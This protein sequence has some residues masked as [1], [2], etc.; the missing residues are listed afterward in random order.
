MAPSRRYG[1][2]LPLP[3]A[4][5]PNTDLNSTSH[6][7]TVPQRGAHHQLVVE[8]KLRQRGPLLASHDF[9]GVGGEVKTQRVPADAVQARPHRGCRTLRRGHVAGGRGYYLINEGVLLNQVRE[10]G[11]DPEVVRESQRRRYADVSVVDKVIELDT[12]WRTVRFQLDQQNKEFNAL[13]K[14]IATLRKANNAVVKTY[15]ELRP[16]TD[17][18]SGKKLYNH[19]DLVNLLG[20][21]NLEAG[22]DVSWAEAVGGREG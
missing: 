7:I 19:V 9:T 22:T 14:E 8:G 16:A 20:I 1:A 5:C 17:A 2:P 12:E 15:G 11:G 10:K 6:P 4:G 18:G 21:V 3:L 13:N